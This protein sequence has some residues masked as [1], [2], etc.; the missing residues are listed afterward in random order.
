MVYNGMIHALRRTVV[1]EWSWGGAHD[2]PGLC[3]CPS[4]LQR[5]CGELGE[6]AGGRAGGRAE[7]GTRA[8]TAGE[9][10]GMRRDGV[11]KECINVAS[12]R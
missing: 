11:G 1:K 3:M 6:R 8:L 4:H 10:A 5:G 12:L 9:Q 2:A 7:E